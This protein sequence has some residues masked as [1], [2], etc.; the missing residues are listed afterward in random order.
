[1]SDADMAYRTTVSTLS[2]ERF[3]TLL[4]AH[5]ILRPGALSTPDGRSSYTVYAQRTNATLDI[6]ALKTHASRFF[7]A[8]LGLTTPKEYGQAPPLTDAANVVLAS[9]DGQ[10]SGTRL[11][12]GRPADDSDRAAAETA[13]NAQN[14]YGM[15]LLAARCPTVWLVSHDTEND[16]VALTIAAIFA[17]VFLGPILAPSGS[18][19]FGV[20]TARMKL[21]N[22]SGPYR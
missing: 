7:G 10:T 14:T 5:G 19:L 16:R 22:S 15:A 21:E 8:R 3:R 1:M 4:D 11:C 9:D 20:R 2:E 17:S 18:E 12:F 6:T 13:E